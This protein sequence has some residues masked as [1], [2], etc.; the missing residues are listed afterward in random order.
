MIKIA[1]LF[2]FV[3]A[4]LL[5]SCFKEFSPKQEPYPLIRTLP[6]TAIDRNGVQF[7]GEMIMPGSSPVLDY[8][9]TWVQDKGAIPSADT[10]LISL[11]S[12]LKSEF[13]IH[14]NRKLMSYRKYQ[15][16]AYVTVSGVTVYGNAVSFTSQTTSPTLI[17]S[18]SSN[19]VLDGD[20]LTI[21]G[22]NFNQFGP[23]S[24]TV[25][26][27]GATLITYNQRS[28]K[29]LVPPIPQA[30]PANVIVNTFFSIA[31]SNQLSVTNPSITSFSPTIGT[32]AP[33]NR[34][35][36]TLTGKFSSYN[37]YGYPNG[38]RQVLGYN[39]VYF[40]GVRAIIASSSKDKMLVYVPDG[41]SGNVNITV[42]VNG[43]SFTTAD[44]FLVH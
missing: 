26:G 16:R 19:E 7:N 40:N 39:R 4:F 32:N 12:E 8:G 34:T 42:D 6:V 11:G 41:V 9:F 38:F 1:H 30:G 24:V 13:N 22:E 17:T 2:L 25:G 14:F 27:K 31:Q 18:F 43:K 44:T 23:D 5:A 10:F 33:N 37:V 35:L 20:T 29:I 36:V 28:V 3:L 15:V 21:Y